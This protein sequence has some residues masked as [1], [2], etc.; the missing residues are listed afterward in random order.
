MSEFEE[1]MEAVEG[2][3]VRE[4]EERLAKARHTYHNGQPI[5]TDD[6]YDAL[7]DELAELKAR[8]PEV[9][10]VGAKVPEDSGWAKALHG[11]PMGS[12]HKV[13]TM[14][15][16]TSWIISRTPSDLD[17]TPQFDEL[18]V[19]EKLDG[20]SIHVKYKR[21]RLVQAITRGDGTTGEDITR[22]VAKMEGVPTN[23]PERFTG[24]LRGE[25]VLHK[26]RL[27]TY[28]P[29]NAN[30]RNTAGGVSHRHDGVGCEH[31]TVYFYQVLDGKEFTTEMEQ[32]E[33]LSS[34][35]F[36]VPNWY[37]TAM[38]PGI[39]TPQDI[40]V[41]Y[42]QSKRA[43]LDYDIDGLVV[44]INQ[45]ARQISLGETDNCPNGAVAFKFKSPARETRATGCL[46]QTGP[47]GRITPVAVFDPVHLLG[48]EVTQASLY[49]WKYI[50][51]IGFDV[52]AMILV[53][54]SNDVIPRV[55]SVSKGTGTTYPEPTHCESCGGAVV[56]EG[57]YYV[58]PHIGS[59]PAQSAGRI[60]RYVQALDIKEWGETL[61]ERLLSS[62]LVKGIPDLY[63]LTADQIASIERM[64]KRSAAA[65]LKSLWARNPIPI[66]QL[67][68]ALSIPLCA[69]STIE[70][71][72]ST[73]I[74][75]F[76]A[77]LAASKEQLQAVPG[78]GPVKAEALHK[79]L[80]ESSGVV[81]ELLGAGVQIKQKVKGALSGMT[82]CFT[83]A[84]KRPRPELQEIVVAC[85]GVVKSSVV[86]N[87]SY[88]VMADAN[89]TTTKAQAARKNGTKTISEEDFLR[90]AGIDPDADTSTGS[91]TP[92]EEVD[93][94]LDALTNISI[95]D[96]V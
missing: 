12:L 2:D 92:A 50:R 52:G 3:R 85:G 42:Q 10:S 68:G 80:R 54:R 6:V 61:V 70:M 9:I 44:R 62:G 23:I 66:E 22:N 75:T 27:A 82:F 30:T 58:C 37:V 91:E 31:L 46:K 8:S 13:K 67:L 74:D 84:S 83:G 86:K 51:E 14:E 94:D 20:I 41:E 25:I 77:L 21:G 95:V 1:L 60:K 89:S 34:L 57:E 45:L 87:L 55:V 29:D 48:A 90:M 16:M 32:F 15:E 88:L 96:E 81:V 72:T 28:F 35:G 4:L 40:W 69:A 56:V 36:F 49:N 19:T 7:Q 39:R 38:V 59:C 63:R 43:T 47:S 53:T 17:G 26:S 64:G 18:L 73:G 33:W 5:M 78:L 65:V 79:W 11:L 93:P 76:D 71:V 24:S